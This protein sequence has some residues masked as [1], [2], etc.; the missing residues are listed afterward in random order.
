MELGLLKI[1][2]NF[3]EKL[4]TTMVDLTEPEQKSINIFANNTKNKTESNLE[5]AIK[6]GNPKKVLKMLKNGGNPHIENVT[7]L[8]KLNID[9]FNPQ[10]KNHR[11]KILEIIMDF[12]ET[13]K[14]PPKAIDVI[15]STID[16]NN[17]E[18]FQ[19]ISKRMVSLNLKPQNPLPT[20]KKLVNS[21]NKDFLTL[22]Q[23]TWSSTWSKKWD[24][25]LLQ[26]AFIQ[27]TFPQ[28]GNN[29]LIQ[30][31][32]NKGA[33]PTNNQQHN[34][35]KYFETKY[36]AN[37]SKDWKD[38]IKNILKTYPQNPIHSITKSQ[39]WSKIVKL[40]AQNIVNEEVRK[41]GNNKTI[42]SK[43]YTLP[44]TTIN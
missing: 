38:R 10:N 35:L 18:A 29:N 1:W 44:S 5:T 40:E 13:L 30:F 41:Y 26:E 7:A 20:L 4:Y 24:S 39:T 25:E 6:N 14:N 34:A 32:L 37:P 27:K 22:Y 16:N 2:D 43:I 8:L 31:F 12:R 11:L 15:K 9:L 23:N 17:I 19:V 36:N 3:T 21:N 33:D 42:Q 28:I